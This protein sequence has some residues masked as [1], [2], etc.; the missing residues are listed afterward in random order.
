M[1]MMFGEEIG[2]NVEHKVD[3]KMKKMFEAEI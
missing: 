2:E 3:K 1:E